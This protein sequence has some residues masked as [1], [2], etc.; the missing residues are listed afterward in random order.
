MHDPCL[1]HFNHI[2]HILWYIKGS[3]DCGFHINSSSPSSLTAY[4]VA[5]WVGCS[6]TRSMLWYYVILCN[7][8]GC[9]NNGSWSLACLLRL[10]SMR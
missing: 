8:Y 5:D 1:P 2:K 7:N 9:L 6:D 10:N 3:L 4:S